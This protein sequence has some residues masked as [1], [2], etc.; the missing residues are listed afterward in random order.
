[1]AILYILKELSKAVSKNPRA[2]G[3]LLEKSKN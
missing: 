1:M 3:N 2:K